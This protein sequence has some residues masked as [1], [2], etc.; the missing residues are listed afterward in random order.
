MSDHAASFI[1]HLIG[2]KDKDRAALAHLKR[3]LAFDPG[4]YPQA[5]PYVERFVG[6]ECHAEDPRTRRAAALVLLWAGWGVTA[7]AGA[8]RNASSPY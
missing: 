3:S 8:S 4:A 2:L 5:Y 7:K 6:A 1:A